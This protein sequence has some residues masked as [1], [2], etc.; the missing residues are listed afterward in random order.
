MDDTVSRNVLV[1]LRIAI[2][3]NTPTI[4][5]ACENTTA[6]GRLVITVDLEP[7]DVV[8]HAGVVRGIHEVGERT[9]GLFEDL[10]VPATWAV[11]E[12]ANSTA[13]GYLT[14]AGNPHEIALLGEPNWVGQKAGRTP[15]ARELVRRLA[16]ASANGLHIT[17]L[18]PRGVLVDDHLD[19]VINNGV[20][21]VRGMVDSAGISRRPARPHPLYYGLWE[22]PGSLRLPGMSALVPGG[23]RGRHARTMLAK[24]ADRA[25]L[26]HL[27]VDIPRIAER[28]RMAERTVARV[29]RFAAR[30]R[31]E[32]KLQIGTLVEIAAIL[33]DATKGAPQRSILRAAG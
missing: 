25:E 21:A 7:T 16:A 9:M 12:P 23:G 32:G 28:G 33:S 6:P 30:L 1:A 13:A 10:R 15:F 8:T 2:M 22:V 11:A 5:M 18:V 17:S 3:P 29:I 27:V 14:T 20:T 31:D 19:L 26:F 24:A 4:D